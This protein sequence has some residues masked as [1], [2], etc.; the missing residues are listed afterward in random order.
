MQLFTLF[1]QLV[2]KV[3]VENHDQIKKMLAPVLEEQYEQNP[4]Q[5]LP[6]ARWADTW[7]MYASI[8]HDMGFELSLIHI[9]EP[10]RPY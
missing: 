8:S 1:P 10:T 2:A 5:Q 9:S 7:N 6:W 3:K 4:N